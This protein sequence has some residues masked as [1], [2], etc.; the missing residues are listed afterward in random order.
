MGATH[1][2]SALHLQV[3]QM[4]HSPFL[5]VQ[6]VSHVFGKKQQVLANLSFALPAGGFTALVGPSGCGCWGG[7]YGRLPATSTTPTSPTA[8]HP[9]SA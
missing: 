4:T 3:E 2:V 7:C 6:N 9:P 1:F 8:S 5:T